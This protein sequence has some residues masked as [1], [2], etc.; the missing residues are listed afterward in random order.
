MS[1]LLAML[2]SRY[3]TLGLY[4]TLRALCIC[5]LSSYFHVIRFSIFVLIFGCCTAAL[6]ASCQQGG[7]HSHTFLLFFMCSLF[8]LHT[9]L[10]LSRERVVR[11]DSLIQ[12]LGR[13]RSGIGVKKVPRPRLPCNRLVLL[14]ISMSQSSFLGPAEVLF[15][16]F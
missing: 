4:L 15:N 5:V 6:A 1:R 8:S 13:Q 7:G 3:G 16:S 11:N 10:Y 2:H 14:G 9:L 12:R